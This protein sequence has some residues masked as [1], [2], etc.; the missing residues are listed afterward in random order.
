[1]RLRADWLRRVL[2][3]PYV[4]TLGPV[5]PDALTADLF[6]EIIAAS[7]TGDALPFDRDRR[8]SPRKRDIV[9]VDEIVHRPTHT[10][11]PTLSRRGT[12]IV[13]TYQSLLVNHSG[14]VEPG[15]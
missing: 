14:L 15:G 13:K 3:V 12:G 10:I 6:D 2:T 8:W 9:L 1:M 11:I 4:P 7:R 5:H